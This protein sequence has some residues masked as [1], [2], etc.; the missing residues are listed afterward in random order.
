MRQ[1]E[2]QVITFAN[3]KGGV[4]KTT[5]VTNIA[6]LLGVELGKRVLVVDADDQGNA[7]KALG[8]RERFDR[9][10]ETLWYALSRKMTYDQVMVESPY[11]NIWGIASTK[12]LK[13]AQTEFGRSARGLKLFKHL[14]KGVSQ[15]F[16]F[17]LI[18]TKPQVSVLLQAALAASNWYV[19]P[20][21]P[22][23]DSYDGFL[24]LVAECEEIHDEENPELKCLGVILSC[25]KKIPAHE[26]YIRF[27]SK[28]LKQARVQL[29]RP[30]IRISNAVATG[31]L[32]SCPAVS[33]ASAR[34][35]KDDY[36]KLTKALLKAVDAGKKTPRPDL[37]LLGVLKE[38][39]DEHETAPEA[40]QIDEGIKEIDLL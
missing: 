27:I 39:Q 5:S 8:L 9:R 13:G 35:L 18:D 23:P 14:L 28:H 17:V 16:D 3:I 30:V 24:D 15:D 7:T 11:A 36:K 4:G 1:S 34:A 40:W 32:H 20:S 29:L 37:G 6:Y 12:E 10:Q 19:I 25:V 38:K 31:C 22:E 26:S 21:F 2:A 33:L